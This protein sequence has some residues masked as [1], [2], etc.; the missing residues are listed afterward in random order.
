MLFVF[1]YFILIFFDLTVFTAVL[2]IG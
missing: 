2:E 1:T